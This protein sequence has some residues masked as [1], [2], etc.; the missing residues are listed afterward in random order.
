M[1]RK[2]QSQRERTLLEKAAR[3][4]PGASLGNTPVKGPMAFVI[5]EGRGSK[6]Y[7]FSGNAY[8]DYLLGSGPMLLGHAHPAVVAAVR[9]YLERG[10]TYYHIN[11]PAIE[12]AEEICKAVRCA[13]KVRFTT[14][15][16]DATFQ[17]LRVARVYRRRDK[18]L[19]F[20]GG[21]HGTHD[22]AQMSVSPKSPKPF[23]YPTPDSGGIPKTVQDLVLVAPFNDLETTT[24]IIEKHHD[25]LAAVIL[26]PV[27]RLLPPRP[28][29][30][31]GVREV[32]E[33][34]G[35]PLVFDEV[36]TG[37]RLAYGGAQ[38][39]YGVAPDLCAIGKV[40]G[41]GMPLGAVCGREELMRAYDTVMEGTPDYIPQI[42]TLSGNPLAATAGLATLKEL[43][44]KGTYSKL[45]AT[46]RKLREALQEV[47]TQ[48]E[49]PATVVGVDSV[50]DV[51]FTDGK[52]TDYRSTLS[53]DKAAMDK[54][55]A[56]LLANGVL[57]GTQKFYVS[58]AHTSQDVKDTIHALHLAA[59]ALRG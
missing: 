48:A 40:V 35:I 23:P 24:A 50:F 20:E 58:L 52:I 18:I 17:C 26:E 10:S 43:R 13:E 27:Q 36:V 44:K 5:K 9:D 4:L 30:L 21:Y 6:V 47:L 37:F 56:T 7:D 34:H 11:G 12:L 46:G 45:S 14:S 29:F 41:G 3:Y 38:E 32:T 16:T 49:I 8:I 1:V 51:F 42:G 39:F 59:E 55:N 28:G 57:K 25:E 2:K 53:S 33:R 54:F 15:G 22:Y 31:Q 19:K